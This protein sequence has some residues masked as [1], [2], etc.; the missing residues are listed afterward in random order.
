MVWIGSRKFSDQVFHHTRWKLNWGCTTFNLLGIEFC[1][2]LD[3][4]TELNYNIQLPK[5]LSLIQQW[6]RRV[7][8][9]VGRV[10][11]AKTL[12]LPKLNHLFISLPTP[13]KAFLSSLNTA[14]FNF[15][16]KSKGD[17]VKRKIVT[18]D[19]TK[20]GL[21]MLD[22]H[23]FVSSLK[24]LWI[25]RLTLKHKPWMDIFFAINGKNVTM[26]MLE[27]G[28]D[29]IR[30]MIKQNNVFWQDV[31]QSWHQVVN[32]LNKQPGYIKKNIIN[33]PIWH[34]S[35]I[36]VA[37]KSFFINVLYQHG[38]KLVGDFLSA[39]GAFLTYDYFLHMFN[40][41]DIYVMQY[42]SII[43]AISKFLKSVFVERVNIE[44]NCTPFLPMYFEVILLNEK[45]TKAI[46]KILNYTEAVPTAIS[47]WNNELPLEQNLCIQDCFKICFMT[48]NDTSVQWLQYR[49]L[50]RILPVNYYLKK[51]KII[52][53]D[54]CTFC[55]EEIETIQHVFFSCTNVLPLWNDLS[56]SIYR[57]TT[58]RVGFNVINILFGEN[59]LSVDNK[60]VNFIILYTKQ[61]IYICLKQNKIPNYVDLLYYLSFKYKIEKYA[62]VQKFQL[63]KFEKCWSQ[64]E[65]LF[66]L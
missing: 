51:I 28:D 52:T 22:V 16:W 17:K 43:S 21:K 38:V 24:C 58:K 25:K 3:K 64:W 50:H 20:G 4:I 45:C 35:C 66:C 26:K 53:N 33:V 46:Y 30:K 27:F 48:T 65:D 44:K 7:L 10:T 31:F 63:R 61:F 9:P 1:V 13:D 42:N 47:R 18:Q 32:M 37:N 36:T 11:V 15:I 62:S 34:N 41:P 55:K 23:N 2:E 8:T 40:L 54:C 6:N 19:Y 59:S 49:V 29:F 14:I 39:N 12:I 57:K 56:M 60:P 5:I